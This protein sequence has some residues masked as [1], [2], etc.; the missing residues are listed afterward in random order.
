MAYRARQAQAMASRRRAYEGMRYQ[1]RELEIVGAYCRVEML[2]QVIVV[3]YASR[4]L[5]Y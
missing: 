2:Y 3:W 1:P 5:L 4:K